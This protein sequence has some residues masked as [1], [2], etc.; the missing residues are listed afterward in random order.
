MICRRDG[1]GHHAAAGIRRAARWRR[2]AVGD[3]P[4]LVPLAHRAV[5][6]RGLRRSAR[7]APRSSSST[8]ES[9]FVAGLAIVALIVILFRDGLEV[10]AEMLQRAWHLPF[11][12]LVL[13]M[14]ITA[15]IVAIGRARAHRP[16]LDRVLPARCAALPDRS[17]AVLQR[18]HEPAGA[19]PRA[20]LAEPRVRP[21]RRPRAAGRAGVLRGAAGRARTT[22]R[23]GDSCSRTSRSGSS[24]DLDRLHRQPP[25]AA[26]RGLARRSRTTRSRSTR[27]APRSPTYGIAVAAARGQ[28]ADRRV[29]LRDHARDSPAR[30]ARRRSSTA[31]RTSS[32]SSSS[33]SSSCSARC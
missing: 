26:R 14:P 10:E 15:A 30:H 29:R 24:R 16:G 21:E 31:P 19:A 28:R 20:P 12:K 25:S 4:S 7:V 33:A 13:A 2:A 23:G 9:G 11:R 3:R 6:A 32:R 1:R 18:G 5:R 22:S 8:R 17:G 27:S